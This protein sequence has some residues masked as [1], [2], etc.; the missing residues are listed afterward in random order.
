[1]GC[2]AT[3][4]F[5]FLSTGSLTSHYQVITICN[6]L[7][8]IL[9]CQNR[10][11][12]LILHRV[13]YGISDPNAQNQCMPQVSCL[14]VDEIDEFNCTGSNICV[15]YPTDRYLF[16]CLHKKSNLTQIHITCVNLGK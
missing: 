8:S 11:H 5:L 13:I 14:Q 2:L 12:F 10:Q 16:N 4:R 15:F 3:W 7:P 1:M 6:T 9:K